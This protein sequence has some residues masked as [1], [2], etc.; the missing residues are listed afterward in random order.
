MKLFY[1]ENLVAIAYKDTEVARSLG[2]LNFK[3]SLTLE[4][5][6]F[7]SIIF[8]LLVNLV[9]LSNSMP[10]YGLHSLHLRRSNRHCYLNWPKQMCHVKVEHWNSCWKFLKSLGTS[11]SKALGSTFKVNLVRYFVM[12]LTCSDQISAYRSFMSQ[13]TEWYDSHNNNS[14]EAKCFAALFIN[15]VSKPLY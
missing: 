8:R 12:I 13:L 15:E 11:A 14:G 9:L 1:L 2:G 5:V 6:P 3:N 7:S 4:K 10:I